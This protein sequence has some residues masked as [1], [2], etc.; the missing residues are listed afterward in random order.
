MGRTDTTNAAASTSITIATGVDMSKLLEELVKEYDDSKP[1][2]GAVTVLELA[3]SLISSKTYARAI[4]ERK[5]KYEGWISTKF[6]GQ[7]HYWKP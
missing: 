5:V 2:K 4:L 3:E 6:R 7:K 1:G